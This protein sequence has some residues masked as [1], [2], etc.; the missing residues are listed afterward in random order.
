[1]KTPSF[2]IGL[3]ACA[4]IAA[5]LTAAAPASRSAAQ[6]PSATPADDPAAELFSQMC[7]RCHDGARITAVRRTKSEWEGVLT[8]MITMGA[9]GS[10]DEFESVFGYLRRH[11][12]KVY[13]N[14]APPDEITTS[15]GLSAKDADAILAYRKANGPFQDFEAVRKVPDLDVKTLDAHK[16]AVAF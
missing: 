1:M 14:T 2:W 13:I 7:S 16:E 12:G 5:T 10:E 6:Q 9:T 8:K 11:Y 4:L 15:L 3:A